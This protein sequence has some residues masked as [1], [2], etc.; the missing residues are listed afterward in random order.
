M[1]KLFGPNN[2][3]TIFLGRFFDLILLN[4]IFI[5]TCL[6]IITIGAA[7]TALYHETIAI[8]KKESTYP[9]RSYFAS[10]KQNFRQATILWSA[11]LVL[12]L[13]FSA[14]LYV[15]YNVIDP[16]YRFLQYPVWLILIGIA[17]V[18]LYAFP[19]LATHEETV[20]QLV[21]NSFLLSL[22][23]FPFTVFCVVLIALIADF[24]L[25]NGSILVGFFSL[26]LFFGCAAMA[27]LFS[28]FFVRIFR[29]AEKH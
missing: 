1:D 25:H 21:R 7:I 12:I 10:F 6:P 5:V 4:V 18:L 14:D 8:V 22:S 24:S 28:V 9:A 16:A 15:I 3:V 19:L 20:P 27:L 29:K 13:F 2:P 23:N 17:S 26:F 11:L